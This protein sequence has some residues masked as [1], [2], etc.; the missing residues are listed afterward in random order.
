MKKSLILYL[1]I[2]LTLTSNIEA[3]NKRSDTKSNFIIAKTTTP[4][5]MEKGNTLS[6]VKNNKSIGHII[7]DKLKTNSKCRTYW[8]L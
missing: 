5:Y 7:N 1:T 6:I 3:A 4:K 8:I 2:I